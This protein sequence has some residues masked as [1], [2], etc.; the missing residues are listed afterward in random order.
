MKPINLA[1]LAG[2]GFLSVA[3][4]PAM[5][6]AATGYATAN[7]N[8]RAGP[9][10]GF[11][12][13]T[14]IPAGTMVTIYGCLSDDTWC[15]ISW[16]GNRGW[17]SS[18]Y[19]QVTYQSRRVVLHNYISDVGIPFITFDVG[20]YWGDHYKNRSFF[21]QESHWKGFKPG[22]NFKPSAN[23][24]GNNANNPPPPPPKPIRKPPTFG[25]GNNNGNSVGN[26]NN[27]NNTLPKFHKQPKLNNPPANPGAGTNPK[28]KGAPKFKGQ[29]KG[30]GQNGANCVIKDG[31][32][33]CT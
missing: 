8:E 30:N 27:N 1:A 24:N 18:S 2:L 21:G 3:M 13:V 26:N 17:M 25:Q 4:T 20:S 22:G 16:N 23:S 19:L 6:S 32:K 31:K 9:S 5:A 33:V 12:A 15:D 11:P 10:T 29:P 14:V 7:V 28:F